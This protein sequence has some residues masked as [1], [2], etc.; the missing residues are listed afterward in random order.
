MP[1]RIISSGKLRRLGGRRIAG[2]S[3]VA[4]EIKNNI[5]AG[6]Q[7]VIKVYTK[8]AK[9]IMKQAYEQILANMEAR[10][11]SVFR[12]VGTRHGMNIPASV[13]ATSKITFNPDGIVIQ[14]GDMDRLEK[15]TQLPPTVSAGKRYNLFSLLREGWGR[16]GGSRPDNYL[17]YMLTSTIDRN[18]PHNRVSRIAPYPDLVR[19]VRTGRSLEGGTHEG[20]FLPLTGRMYVFVK[21]PGFRGYDWIRRTSTANFGEDT[22]VFS[23]AVRK[24]A[25]MASEAFN[26][27]RTKFVTVKR[28]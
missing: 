7:A 5:A 10:F 4:I 14:I 26:K 15:I 12:G 16:R 20:Y 19:K 25:K 28:R 2:K 27:K 6:V 24:V 21:H 23:D 9:P 3:F 11:L 17:I 13:R 1:R 22:K 8:E 18:R